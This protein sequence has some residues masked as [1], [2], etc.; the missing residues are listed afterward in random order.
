MLS[1]LPYPFLRFALFW[2]GGCLLALGLE[3]SPGILAMLWPVSVGI[4]Y[5]LT[6]IYAGP[7]SI[8]QPYLLGT[9]ALITILLLAMARTT[10]VRSR[11]QP[12]LQLPQ[13]SSYWGRVEAVNR[14]TPRYRQLEV[15]IILYLSD[16]ITQSTDNKVIWYEDKKIGH[17]LHI[18]DRVLVRGSPQ[19]IPGPKNPYQFDYREYLYRK[20]IQWRHR[21]GESSIIKVLP[22]QGFYLKRIIH[23]WKLSFKQRLRQHLGSGP[24]F[25]IAGAMLLGDRQGVSEE[26]EQAYADSGTIHVLAVSGLHLGI[27]YGA[28]LYLLGGWRHRPVMKWAFLWLALIL[29]WTFALLTG[30][31][32]STRRAAIMFSLLLV[33]KCW[34]RRGNS[35]NALALSACIILYID[36]YELYAVGFQLSYLALAGILYLQPKLTLFLGSMAIRSSKNWGKKSTKSQSFSG[37]LLKRAIQYFSDILTV[38][39]TAQVMVLPLTTYYFHQIPLYFLLGNLFIIPLTLLILITGALFLLMGFSP[40]LA[41]F[42]G[43]CLKELLNSAYWFTDLISSIPGSVWDGLWIDELELIL[44]YLATLALLVLLQVVNRNSLWLLFTIWALLLFHQGWKYW[45]QIHRN[46]L[47]VYHIPGCTAMDFIRGKYYSSVACPSL[48]SKTLEYQIS[49]MRNQL[50]VLPGEGLLPKKSFAFGTAWWFSNKLIVHLQNPPISSFKTNRPIDILIISNHALT[51]LDYLE[52]LHR[53]TIVLVDHSNDLEYIQ[54][55]Q[56]QTQKGGYNFRNL[57]EG[58]QVINLRSL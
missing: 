1:W 34:S 55:L 49:P 19:A 48:S 21:L 44:W 46:W 20:G 35:F 9:A 28:L 41:K 23:R 43:F 4:F 50:G 38:S 6:F 47:V 51:G 33:G 54:A 14:E 37:L 22:V 12:D 56:Q 58:D 24:A 52:T 8:K 10:E 29:M 26:V 31:A 17:D 27:L 36:P 25:M 45:H 40:W 42:L 30:M 39:L 16:S 7:G 53:N 11:R 3:I 18:G 32:P 15:S 57:S 5:T 2:V 13:S